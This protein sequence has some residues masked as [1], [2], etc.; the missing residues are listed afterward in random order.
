MASCV[1]K[2]RR[3]FQ[4]V[5]RRRG[6]PKEIQLMYPAWAPRMGK[7]ISE[8]RSM[9]RNHCNTGAEIKSSPCA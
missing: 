1:K 7:A 3:G 4:N 5:N 9:S 6:T 8:I 2:H